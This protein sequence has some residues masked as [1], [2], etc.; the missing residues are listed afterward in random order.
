[1]EDKIQLGSL[2]RLKS[3][4]PTMTVRSF[5]IL[6]NVEVMDQQEVACDWFDG[7]ENHGYA[8]LACQLELASKDE[9]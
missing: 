2:V 8:F 3:G 4:G 1:M 5:S 6:S 9:Q 7:R